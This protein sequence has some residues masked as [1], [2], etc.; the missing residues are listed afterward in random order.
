MSQTSSEPSKWDFRQVGREVSNWGR[1][2]TED[3]RGTLNLLT[4]ELIKSAATLVRRGKTF[5]LGIALDANGPQDGSDRTNPVHVMTETGTGQS[6]PGSFRCADDMIFMFLQAGSQF[7][8]LA[9]V[10]YDDLLYNGYSASENV[11]PYGARRCSIDNMSPG[12][13]GR[14]VLLDVARHR[15]VPWLPDRYAV[16]ATDLDACAAAQ[17][18]TVEAG[19]ILLVRTGWRRKYLDSGDRAAFWDGEPGLSFGCASW[20]R[21][22]DVTLVGSDNWGVEVVPSEI[23]GELFPLHMVAIRDMGLPLAEMLDFEDLAEDCVA[24]GVWEFLFCGATLKF[25]G[26]V[27]TPVNPLALK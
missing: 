2:G 12:V 1:W 25:T 22:R 14:G 20:L 15:G 7:D 6:F 10:F 19:D 4:E 11:D 23:D 27:G 16:T 26:A 5:E 13:V 8:S 18:V 17:G 9:H 24:D 21:D 3:E